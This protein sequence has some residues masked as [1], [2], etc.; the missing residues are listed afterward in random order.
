[1]LGRL[2]EKAQ[3]AA[4]NQC[5]LNIK[6]TTKTLASVANEADARIETTGT[7]SDSVTQ[8]VHRAQVELL[9][10]LQLGIA[11]GLSPTEVRAIV[12]ETIASEK[13]SQW[14]QM[15]IAHVFKSIEEG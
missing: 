13:V 12:T 8:R 14:P 11:N 9:K 5:K 7:S 3:K 4:A 1:M 6:L 2:K 15:A 10:D